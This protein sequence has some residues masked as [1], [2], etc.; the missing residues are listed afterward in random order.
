LTTES[1]LVQCKAFEK[2]LLKV[3][4]KKEAYLSDEEKRQLVKFESPHVID[5][6]D[7]EEENV[8]APLTKKKKIPELVKNQ[9]IAEAMVKKMKQK[10]QK[11]T[12]DKSLYINLDYIPATSNACESNTK[13]I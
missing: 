7:E 9:Q 10:Q 11:Q 1:S 3:F 4:E 13:F 2:A 5:T 8:A 12:Q 6:A